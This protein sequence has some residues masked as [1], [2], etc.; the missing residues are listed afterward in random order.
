MK[1]FYILV[2]VDVQYYG[3]NAKKVYMYD[4]ADKAKEKMKELYLIAFKKYCNEDENPFATDNYAYEF[5][6]TYAYVDGMYYLDIFNTDIE[7]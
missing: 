7:Q 4:D 5:G 3:F 6:D 2:E 1:R